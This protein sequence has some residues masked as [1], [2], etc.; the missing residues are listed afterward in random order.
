[1][2]SAVAAPRALVS[3][4]SPALA[5]P[6][7]EPARAQRILDRRPAF[8]AAYWRIIAECARRAPAVATDRAYLRDHAKAWQARLAVIDS[9]Q[10][11]IVCSSYCVE[12][13]AIGVA[14]ID[15][16]IAARKRGVAV[17][18]GVD[19][20]AQR[21]VR[22]GAD[23]T[24]LAALDARFTEL[25]RLGGRVVHFAG[26]EQ[27]TRLPG[28]GVHAKMLVVDGAHAIAGGSAR[29]LTRAPH[30]RF[31]GAVER[32]VRPPRDERL[33]ALER[34]AAVSLLLELQHPQ[35]VALF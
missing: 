29:L 1:M 9:A 8:D 13:D 7:V 33:S 31:H 30:C 2:L 19:T 3:L 15:A 5:S 25:A 27:Q 34:A 35:R 21:F 24:W 32:A 17:A 10:R 6:L 28:C 18:I 11:E 20:L 4:A 23:P 16:L 22:K 26:L 14:Y 12:P